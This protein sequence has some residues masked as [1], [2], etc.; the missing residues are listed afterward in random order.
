MAYWLKLIGTTENPVT[1]YTEDYADSSVRKDDW[2]RIGD[3]IILY[4]TAHQVVF[5]SADVVSEPYDSGRAQWPARVDI[6]YRK[7]PLPILNG[8]HVSQ[9]ADDNHKL[10][11]DV[12]H[13]SFI[14]ISEDEFIRAESVLDG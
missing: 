5:A 13:Q 3:K 4:A 8:V 10:L 11:L 14:S 6:R 2:I 7:G 9:I 1:A 12:Q